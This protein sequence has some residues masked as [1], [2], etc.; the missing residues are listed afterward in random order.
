MLPTLHEPTF[1][2][3]VEEVF[4][5]SDDP[6]QNFQLR[7]VIAISMQKMSPVYAGL[8]DSY[9]LAALPYLEASLR[10]RD[11]RSLQCLA[12]IAQYS[13]LTPT[14]TAAY[15]VV[16]MA[17][18][19]CQDL[20]LTDEATITRS[21]DGK[22]LDP[23]EIDMRRRLFWIVISMEYGLS[24]S[25]GRPNCYSVCHDHINVKFFEPVE[26]HNITREGIRPGARIILPKCIAIHFF[27]M[28]LLQAEIRRILYLNKRDTPNND[29]DPWFTQMI[30][31]IDDWVATCPKNDGGSGLSEKWSAQFIILSLHAADIF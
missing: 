31:K 3:D 12:L 21:S 4:N 2:K 30:R 26:D 29:Q 9:Y 23:L 5:G 6:C 22:L 19:L 7:I 14:R 25:L 18:K 10:R 17:V 8:A 27:K 15:W 11:L 1:R 24:H 16:G 20:G 28:R 13:M